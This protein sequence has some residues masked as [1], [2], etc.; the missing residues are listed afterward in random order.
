MHHREKA[1]EFLKDKEFS[2]WQD[3]ALWFVRVK[4]DMASK[5]VKEWEKLREIADN[6][7]AHTLSNLDKYL[8]EFE[9]KALKN[10]IEVHWAKD[11]LEHNRIVYDIL[12][13]NGAKKVVKSKSMLTEE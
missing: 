2:A 9:D 5:S 6:I 10:G 4:R 11:A 8:V 1:K 3:E 7:K 12:K 13:K